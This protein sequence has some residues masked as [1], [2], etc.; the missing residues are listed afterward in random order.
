M[1]GRTVRAPRLRCGWNARRSGFVLSALAVCL[2]I[3]SCSS[4]TEPTAPN[5][6]LT[7]TW[8]GSA[9]RGPCGQGWFEDWSTVQLTLVQTEL[10]VTGEIFAPGGR[11]F[12][13]SSTDAVNLGVGG[14]EGSS[15]CYAF[16]FFISDRGYDA[17]GNLTRFSGT[18]GGRCCGT[19]AGSF[20]FER[21]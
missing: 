21:R 4:P 18:I 9:A 7:G 19:V 15:T 13:I 1:S 17:R 14:L 5:D 8:Q 11:R 6:T 16:G 3:A 2:A 20:S 10:S 12:A